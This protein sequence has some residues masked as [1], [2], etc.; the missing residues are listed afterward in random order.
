M[1][2]KHRIYEWLYKLHPEAYH[3]A[4][5]L[6]F[7]LALLIVINAMAVIL[8]SVES[9]SIRYAQVFAIIER[10]SVLIFTI[11]YATRIWVANLA[12]TFQKPITGRLRYLLTPMA[13]V[14][15]MAI[16]PS[17]VAL[18]GI[19]LRILRTLRLLRLLKLTRYT[20]GL[21]TL[22]HAIRRCAHEVAISTLFMLLLILI[23]SSLIYCAE[24]DAQPELFSSIPAA[25]WWSIS[26]LAT[27][28]Y[29][30]IYPIT[31]AGKLTAAITAVF[32][33][34]LFALPGGIIAAA[35]IE[36]A[37]VPANP[38]LHCGK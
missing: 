12:P 16:L 19:D 14:D 18:A 36:T 20:H 28:G 32:G 31:V 34:G 11:E 26:T 4:H 10:I 38:C 25:W 23:S 30:D 5:I 37:R 13:L 29:G 27:I 3:S 8:E 22:T 2:I 24:H 33:I 17:L 15:L 6:Q 35:L 9:L 7:S 21:A 1:P